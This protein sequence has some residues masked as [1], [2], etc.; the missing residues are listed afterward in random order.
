MVRARDSRR[1]RMFKNSITL[2]LLALSMLAPA[3]TSSA[4]ADG[5][6]RWS[7]AYAGMSIGAASG[8]FDLKS[9]PNSFFYTSGFASDAVLADYIRNNAST[10]LDTTRFTSGG[11]LG[12]NWQHGMWVVGLEADIT[13]HQLQTESQRGNLIDSSLTVHRYD[14]SAKQ[15]FLATLRPRVGIAFDNVLVY[16]TAGLAYGNLVVSDNITLNSGAIRFQGNDRQWM[17]GWVYGAGA[18]V[19][20]DRRWSIKGEFLRSEFGSLN[21]SAPHSSLPNLFWVDHSSKLTVDV[22]RAGLN[23]KF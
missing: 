12:A 14:Q 10:R 17:N 6:G 22:A 16:G 23:Y 19:Q 18:E 7:G 3:A 11:Q 13:F 2:A 21:Y 15:T 9:R 8:E 1:C 20:L 4:L 5:P